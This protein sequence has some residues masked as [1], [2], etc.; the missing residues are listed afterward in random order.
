MNDEEEFRVRRHALAPVG[1]TGRL[2]SVCRGFGAEKRDLVRKLLGSH[3]ATDE[4]PG[5]GLVLPESTPGEHRRGPTSSSEQAR[6][7]GGCAGS[8]PLFL[9]DPPSNT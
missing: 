8:Q 2:P 4:V 5:Y 6:T 1:C 3:F 9:T 7:I